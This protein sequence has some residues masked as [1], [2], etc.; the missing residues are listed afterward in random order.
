MAIRYRKVATLFFSLTFIMVERSFI[1]Q[2]PLSSQV[3]RLAN[4][5]LILSVGIL[6]VTKGDIKASL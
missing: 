1:Q 5:D 4:E 2:S 3:D 6:L